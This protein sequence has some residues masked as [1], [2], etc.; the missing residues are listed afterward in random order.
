MRWMFLVFALMLSFSLSNQARASAASE[1]DIKRACKKF[2]AMSSAEQTAVAKRSKK[3]SRQQ[4][5]WACGVILSRTDS[6]GTG[7]GG[8][9]T[10]PAHRPE[11][12][13][14]CR[15]QGEVGRQ[16]VSG[17]GTGSTQSA[18]ES[19]ARS[20]CGW[21][22]DCHVFSCSS[23]QF[24][25]TVTWTCWA[26]GTTWSRKETFDG[27]TEKDRSSAERSA[28]SACSWRAKDCSIASCS[29]R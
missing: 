16:R 17:S 8:H 24:G 18:A 22:S 23:R 4:M 2:L 26:E 13:W 15:A 28:L 14:Q 25:T 12:S 10:Q 9:E 27:S 5:I 20:R 1:S 29:S 3:Y 19:S 7:G 6:G 11:P 21:G